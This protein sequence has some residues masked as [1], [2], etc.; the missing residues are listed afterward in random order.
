MKTLSHLLALL[1]LAAALPCVAQSVAEQQ[2]A[3]VI[4]NLRAAGADLSKPHDI[5]FFLMLP[6]QAQAQAAAADMEQLGYT[7][8]TVE[9]SPQ[10][11]LWEVYATRRMVPQLEAMTAITRTLEALAS[12]YGGYYDGWGTAA[13][14]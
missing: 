6:N 3:H 1:L 10:H 7:V 14:E 8:V 4:E 9:V 13:V 11:L 2:D 12:K 5:D